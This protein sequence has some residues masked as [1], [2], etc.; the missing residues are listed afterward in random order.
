MRFGS[1]KRS[2]ALL[3][4]A[5]MV[6]AGSLW[7][8]A[9]MAVNPLHTAVVSADPA[10]WTPNIMNG[11]VNAI[12]QVGNRIFVG[13]TFSTVQNAGSG[14]NI[15]RNQIF[16][17][18]ATTGTVDTGFH[19][20]IN[21]AVEALAP[22]PDLNS[23]Y[24]G[25]NFTTVNGTGTSYRRLVRLNVTNG[26]IVTGFA[27]RPNRVVT[28]LVLRGG[29]LYASGEFTTLDGPDRSGLA[30]FNTTTG[31]VDPNLDL[32]F[33]NPNDV[34]ER[35]PAKDGR[36]QVWKID[37]TPNGSTLVAIG[38]F[39][40][41][42]GVPRQQIA[43]LNVGG[44]GA[45][46]VSSWQ[47]DALPFRQDALTSWCS[48][49]F[50][51]Y[52]RDLDI[53]PDG[54]YFALV[55]TGANRPNRLCDSL[56]RWEIGPTGPGQLPTW[57]IK[58]GGDSTH[59]VAV[60]G[61]AIYDGGHQQ[62][63]NNPFNPTP[64]GRCTG[65]FPGGVAR[66]GVSAHDPV[67]GLPFTW[68][69]GRSRGKG[70]LAQLATTAGIFFGS[71]TDQIAGE[72]HRKLAFMPLSGGFTVPPNN[73]YTLPG[74]LYQMETGTGNLLRR[75]NFNGS[76]AS[77]V[78]PVTVNTG[79]NWTDARGAFALNGQLYT[80]WS[81]GTLQVRSFNGSAV[82][83]ASTINLYGLDTAPDP[84][85]RMRGADLPIP[86]LDDHLSQMTG[87]AFS[88]GRIYYTVNGDPRLYYRYFTPQSQIVGAELFVP[89]PD[90]DLND[91]GT[92]DINWGNVRG[93]TIASNSMFFALADGSLNRVGWSN[94]Q[95][96][97][98]VVQLSAPGT[99]WD[100][101]GLFVAP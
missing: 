98:P 70:V 59:S 4:T 67:N 25:G 8:P 23:V 78:P 18:N 85:F 5:V 45:A 92:V 63:M 90:G 27:P 20:T 7:A 30:R 47:T 95:P 88:S 86:A 94:G 80:G 43:M 33:A 75:S 28:D 66:L 19:P 29:W 9:A 21:G 81:D 10:N 53:S 39:G 14:T 15:T 58:T 6:V 97:L 79:V 57:E 99:G 77:L 101:R 73:P 65:P 72:T 2:A 42:G 54:S 74:N 55:T 3:V 61:S 36:L 46:T 31:V 34:P 24:V 49:T 60:T 93:M 16:A 40:T 100:S 96:T 76:S 13:G 26:Q 41:V 37:V 64:C 89:T 38:N 83:Q 91:D 35:D 52:L 11:R 32:P 56:T 12:T 22:G 50:P 87:M 82:G 69:P 71:D 84:I 44:A 62:W 51:M 48:S 17:F 68:N 1:K